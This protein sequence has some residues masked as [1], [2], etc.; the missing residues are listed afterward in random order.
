VAIAASVWWTTR[1]ESASPVAVTTTTAVAPTTT[2]TRTAEPA[3]VVL[4]AP[5]SRRVPR[6]RPRRC[7]AW[8]TRLVAAGSRKRDVLEDDDAWLARHGLG[9]PDLADPAA[10]AIVPA[11]VQGVALTTLLRT[12]AGL[13][14]LYGGRYLR[15]SDAG[16]ALTLDLRA[17][18]H[19][20]SDRAN[21]MRDVFTDEDYADLIAQ[22]VGWAARIGSTRRLRQPSRDLRRRLGR[23]HRVPVRVR[24]GA[25]RARLARTRPLV[26]RA[27][28]FLVPGACRRGYG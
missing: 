16:G 17:F 5:P 1:H 15:V 18:F 19:G 10:R 3:P 9:I 23:P 4:P 7:G 27:R 2:T 11:D 14:A 8:R 6:A 21:Y 28:N 13:A 26:A 12:P 20:P 25:P 24:R 22:K